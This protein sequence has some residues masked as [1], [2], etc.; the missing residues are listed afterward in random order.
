MRHGT[1]ILCHSRAC[2]WLIVLVLYLTPIAGWAVVLCLLA[3][4]ALTW[5]RLRK[6]VMRLAG[7]DG[8]RCKCAWVKSMGGGVA[9]G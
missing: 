8:A 9:E 1:V 6:Q 7:W 5:P 3:A 2:G 4:R